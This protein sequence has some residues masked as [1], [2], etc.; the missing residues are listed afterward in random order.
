MDIELN[1]DSA[2]INSI[3]TVNLSQNQMDALL[4]YTYQEGEYSYIINTFINKN[5][6]IEAVNEMMSNGGVS[7]EGEC[8][9]LCNRRN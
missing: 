9:G 6:F 8:N 1:R 4:S 5:D 7:I 2:E 3:L